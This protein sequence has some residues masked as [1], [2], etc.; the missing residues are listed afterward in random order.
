MM[1]YDL[2]WGWRIILAQEFPL[3]G[4]IKSEYKYHSLEKKKSTDLA[5]KHNEIIKESE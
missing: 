5:W 2:A 4:C 3:Q 1:N